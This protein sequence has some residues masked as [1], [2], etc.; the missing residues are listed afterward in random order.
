[1]VVDDMSTGRGIITNTLD[2]I[3]ITH[4]VGESDGQK[5]RTTLED[6]PRCR[7]VLRP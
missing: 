5:A 4:W 3:G 2:K 7:P 6:A 1:M